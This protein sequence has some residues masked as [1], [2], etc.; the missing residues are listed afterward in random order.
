VRSAEAIATGAGVALGQPFVAGRRWKAHGNRDTTLFHR[1]VVAMVLGQ[2]LGSLA[3]GFTQ[4]W[5]PSAR[6]SVHGKRLRCARRSE[7]VGVTP[8]AH[9]R[10]TRTGTG[11]S[12][13]TR[14]RVPSLTTQHLDCTRRP[15]H[16]ALGCHSRCRRHR[17]RLKTR[18]A[19]RIHP[20]AHPIAPHG[21]PKTKGFRYDESRRGVQSRTV[22]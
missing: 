9:C 21:E 6:G 15:E 3:L 16:A 19:R 8:A 11:D 2:P 4:R 13:L 5:R 17:W 7:R 14:Y 18:H 20:T 22:C 1:T 12:R 10:E